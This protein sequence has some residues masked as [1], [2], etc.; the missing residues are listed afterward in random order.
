MSPI[1]VSMPGIARP[2]VVATVSAESPSRHM[3]T[4]TASVI[5]NAVTTL[6]IAGLLAASYGTDA[7]ELRQDDLTFSNPSGAQR[8]FTTARTIDRENPFFQDLGTNGRSCFSCRQATTRMKTTRS[9]R[10]A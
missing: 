5:P 8:T 2:F 4:T 9:L 10:C 1:L 6:S 3:V 7:V